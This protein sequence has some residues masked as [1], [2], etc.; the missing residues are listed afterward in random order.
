[1]INYSENEKLYHIQVAPGTCGKYVILPGDPGRCKKIAAYL[2][3]PQLAAHN[4]N[5]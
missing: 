1:M 3:H 2:E 4:R 5:M